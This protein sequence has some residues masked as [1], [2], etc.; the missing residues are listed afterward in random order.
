MQNIMINFGL[1]TWRKVTP[2]DIRFT[3]E[4]G[5]A[6]KLINKTGAA[7]V[8]GTPVEA[9]DDVDSSFQKAGAEGTECIGTIYE[10]GAADGAETWVCVAGKVPFLLKDGTAC[11]RGNWISTSDTEGVVDAT[12]SS[13]A[14]AP[15]HFKEIGH[16]IQTVASGTGVTAFGVMHFN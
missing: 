9:G 5:L 10:D 13:P 12:A 11:A 15:N 14:A 1:S 3:A 4:G 16:C 7:A 8:R 2:L 6:I